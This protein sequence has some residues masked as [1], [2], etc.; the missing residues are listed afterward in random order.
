MWPDEAQLILRK[1]NTFQTIHSSIGSGR[2]EDEK[3][4][5]NYLFT[6]LKSVNL[7]EMIKF[8]LFIDDLL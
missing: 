5:I 7:H 1:S 8:L 2:H 4:G 3:S 6:K